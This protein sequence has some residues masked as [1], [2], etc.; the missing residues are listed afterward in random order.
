[1]NLV[2]KITQKAKLDSRRFAK[3]VACRIISNTVWL[4]FIRSKNL[5]PAGFVPSIN[6]YDVITSRL[7]AVPIQKWAELTKLFNEANPIR[8]PSQELDS[9]R[10]TLTE[11]EAGFSIQLSALEKIQAKQ[12]VL[13]AFLRQNLVLVYLPISKLPAGETIPNPE[14]YDI[15]IDSIDVSQSVDA[16]L[17]LKVQDSVR[18]FKSWSR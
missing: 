8:T 3:S 16:E 18:G 13:V 17:I 5:I 15:I 1:M 10:N 2:N 9:L 12:E 4:S 7:L 6:G 11:N 14:I